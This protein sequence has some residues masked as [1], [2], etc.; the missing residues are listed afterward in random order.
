VDY[1]LVSVPF[2]GPVGQDIHRPDEALSTH[3]V[4]AAGNFVIR[5]ADNVKGPHRRSCSVLCDEACDMNSPDNVRSLLICRP[6]VM[7]SIV[8]NV[9]VITPSP[10]KTR[11]EL[12]SAV[13]TLPQVNC[14]S[15]GP[16]LPALLQS[17]SRIY[18]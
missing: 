15:D 12:P 18:C 17:Q 9:W 5:V 4:R 14:A 6:T 7:E 16:R 11:P 13:L 10:Y 8:S 1:Q 3:R 2:V